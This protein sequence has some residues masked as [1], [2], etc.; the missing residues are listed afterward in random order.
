[1]PSGRRSATRQND[2]RTRQMR[3]IAL[4]TETVEIL[5]EHLAGQDDRIRQLGR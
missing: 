2:T 3:R 1:M 4:N 5:R